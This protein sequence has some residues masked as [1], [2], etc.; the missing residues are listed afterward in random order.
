M[1]TFPLTGSQR[2]QALTMRDLAKAAVGVQT[3]VSFVL[4]GRADK[5]SSKDISERIWA[6]SAR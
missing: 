2:M 5:E 1:S 3:A 6:A 4:N